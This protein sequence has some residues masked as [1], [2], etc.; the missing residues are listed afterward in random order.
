[1]IRRVWVGEVVSRETR[2][3]Y[4]MVGGGRVAPILP[5]IRTDVILPVSIGSAVALVTLPCRGD[6]RRLFPIGRKRCGDRIV[7]CRWRRRGRFNNVDV[8][9]PHPPLV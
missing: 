3:G 1:M 5:M 6:D 8:L 2:E 7:S 9:R 4:A